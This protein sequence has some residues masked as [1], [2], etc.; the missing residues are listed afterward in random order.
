MSAKPRSSARKTALP[1]LAAV[2]LLGLRRTARKGVSLL[3]G[4]ATSHASS[5]YAAVK[6]I[7]SGVPARTWADLRDIGFTAPELASILGISEKTIARKQQRRAPLDV[8][9]GDR[10]V[11]LAQIVVDAAQAFGDV[12]KAF[13][14]LRKPNR[15]MGGERPIDLIATEPGAALV[16]QGLGVIE[17]GGLS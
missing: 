1:V 5:D 3:S 12:D 6:A 10:T 13:A 8:V 11:R 2:E 17:Y 7:R 16:R 14:W 4:A 15:V 9:E